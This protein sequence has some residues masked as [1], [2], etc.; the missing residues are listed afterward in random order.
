[1]R[2]QYF[3]P[4]LAVA[5]AAG[6]SACG[7]GDGPGGN[8]APAISGFADTSLDQDTSSAPIRFTVQDAE[9]PPDALTI[10]VESSDPGLVAPAG[11]VLSGSGSNRN[12]VVT[13]EPEA[14]GTTT[15]TVRVR[16]TAGR[17]TVRSAQVSVNPVLV[18]FS[19]LADGAFGLAETDEPKAVRGFTVTADVDDDPDAFTGLLQ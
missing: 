17:E 16:D 12:L 8:A 18:A 7:G 6:L 2:N 3:L 4:A 19:G 10:S 11:L 9:T 14:T 5:L 15:V 13:P 1:M